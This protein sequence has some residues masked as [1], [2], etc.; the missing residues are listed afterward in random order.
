VTFHGYSIETLKNSRLDYSILQNSQRE[1]MS[2]DREVN[3]RVHGVERF[4]LTGT[5]MVDITR[6]ITGI[7]SDRKIARR[8]AEEEWAIGADTGPP[9]LPPFCPRSNRTRQRPRHLRTQRSQS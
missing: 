9:V 4:C 2:A 5:E 3:C 1:A 7:V 6:G 8:E